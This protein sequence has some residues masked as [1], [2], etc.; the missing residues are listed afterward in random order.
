[1]KLLLV[2]AMLTASAGAQQWFKVADE[3]TKGVVTLPA[4]S[5]YRYGVDTGKT[6]AGLDCSK[7]NCW[8]GATVD[9]DVS[10]TSVYWPAGAFGT[11][12]PA[13]GL[14]KALY[15]FETREPQT[16]KIGLLT[17][18]V[19]PLAAPLSSWT[20]TSCTLDIYPDGKA[21]IRSGCMV[22]KQ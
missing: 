18:T 16:V 12:D 2:L 6:T 8:T 3:N 4:G 11:I 22:T 19:P 15:V 5:I 9:K 20:L 17:V 10:F 7:S 13:P 21:Q 1:M 14:L